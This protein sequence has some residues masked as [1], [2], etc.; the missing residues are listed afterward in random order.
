[1]STITVIQAAD[2]ITNSRANLN[3]NFA[4]LNTDKLETSVLDTDT[5]LAANSDSKVATQKAV[6]AYVD[7]GGNTNA[8]VSQRGLVQ[9]AIQDDI[10][11][12]TDT[13]S[14]GARLFITP[15]LLQNNLGE[16]G[17]ID[18][19]TYDNFDASTTPIPVA[20]TTDGSLLQ[21][22]ADGA[23]GARLGFHGFTKTN[24]SSGVVTY[25][26]GGTSSLNSSISFSVTAPAGVNRYMLVFTHATGS[27]VITTNVSWNGS[28]LTSLD[29]ETTDSSNNI[30]TVWG[31]AIG[32]SVTDETYTVEAT[33]GSGTYHAT[34]VLVY[35]N[36]DQTTGIA[37]ADSAWA[38]STSVT[39]P[40]LTKSKAYSMFVYGGTTSGGSI[41]LS[42]SGTT[43]R[44]NTGSNR[45]KT[46][47]FYSTANNTFTVTPDSSNRTNAIGVVLNGAG[48][49][50]GLYTGRVVDGFTGL[51]PG[52]IYYLSNT[53]GTIGT[54]AGSTSIPVGTALSATQ[55][56]IK[57]SYP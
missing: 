6:K 28:S 25:L 34:H 29:T 40:S 22:E 47:D 48:T 49:T 27:P 2:L 45:F 44:A 12:S 3:D 43:V 7:A 55:L 10:D 31:K 1:M 56:L 42:N 50:C 37:D 36:V 5:T 39:T 53:I 15:S 51:T 14:S 9:E 33:G 23:S 17:V 8:S 13:G 57:A 11:T 46:G 18:L 35:S 24:A 20:I 16:V 19:I 4:A 52:S 26:G 54:S 32:T 41:T 38:N 21:A 30:S